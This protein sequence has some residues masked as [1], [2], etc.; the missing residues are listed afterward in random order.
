VGSKWCLLE[1]L[2]AKQLNKRIFGVVVVTTPLADIPAEMTAEWQIVDL[3]AGDRTV[4]FTVAVP[5]QSNAT[6]VAYSKEG[7]ARLKLG[8]QKSGLDAKFFAWPPEGDPNR[9]PYRGL[10]PL[11]PEDAGIF[12][13]ALATN[14]T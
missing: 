1:L 14:G 2:L 3:V 12:F 6:T 8:L 10:R 5:Q 13:D 9:P 7:L 11:E 4:I